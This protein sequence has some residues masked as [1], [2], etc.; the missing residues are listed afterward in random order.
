MKNGALNLHLR[1]YIGNIAKFVEFDTGLGWQMCFLC[2]ESVKSP[3]RFQRS[4]QRNV[5]KGIPSKLVGDSTSKGCTWT[6]GMAS[7]GS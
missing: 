5:S 6:S 3:A 4:P 1:V 7:G 2:H